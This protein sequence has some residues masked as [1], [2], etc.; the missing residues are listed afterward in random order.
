MHHW[1]MINDGF[2]SALNAQLGSVTLIRWFERT[3]LVFSHSKC[4][5][6]DRVTFATGTLTDDALS[7]WN[8]HTQ[9]IGIEHAN[10]ITW[11]E[12]KRLLQTRIVL[13]LLVDQKWKNEIYA[14]HRG[15]TA[16]HLKETVN[17]PRKP[18]NLEEDSHYFQ[19][20]LNNDFF[21]ISEVA[22]TYF[23]Q[24]KF[25]QDSGRYSIFYQQSV[26]WKISRRVKWKVIE[27][28][29]ARSGMDSKMVK[30]APRENWNREPIRRN[31]T[32]EIIETK[33]L[34]AQDGLGYD[35]SDQAREGP[36]NFALMTYIFGSV[37]D[38]YKT[39][40]GYHSVLPPY[41]GNFMPLKSDLVLADEDEYVFSES[42]TSVPNVATSKVKTSESKP[43][44]VGEPLIEDWIS[45]NEDENEIE[46]KSK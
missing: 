17:A 4:T 27:Q 37:N 38:K 43:K 45:D 23:I 3:E 39:S 15:T 32:V 25:Y 41:I 30:L 8:V 19:R 1:V 16:K 20:L 46:F 34:V 21:S 24:P 7:W 9:P 42:V 11:T 33:A 10:Q 26:A 2:S 13:E 28:V 14:F 6:E 44:S 29:A 40:E 36:I 35:W 12:L 18:K 5:K 31:V 22:S